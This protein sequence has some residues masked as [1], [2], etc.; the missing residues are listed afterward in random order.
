[1]RSVHEDRGLSSG[2]C[3][4]IP[5]NRVRP[6]LRGSS[7]SLCPI[8][9]HREA[10]DHDVSE[11]R[12][13]ESCVKG[14]QKD[15]SEGD[16]D[17]V[18]HRS[19]LLGRSS[20]GE[21]ANDLGSSVLGREPLGVLSSA[22]LR[23]EP[24]GEQFELSILSGS[25]E[26]RARSARAAHPEGASHAAAEARERRECSSSRAAET[27]IDLRAA[28]KRSPA[29]AASGRTAAPASSS[30]ANCTG[31]T[32]GTGA[33]GSGGTAVSG[34]DQEQVRS[35][36]AGKAGADRAGTSERAFL[37]ATG[38]SEP[39][40]S[41]SARN[42]AHDTVSIPIRLVCSV[43]APCE[44]CDCSEPPADISGTGSGSGSHRPDC[45]RP[46]GSHEPGAASVSLS[47]RGRLGSV[48]PIIACADSLNASPSAPSHALPHATQHEC[49]TIPL[50]MTQQ[51]NI[52]HSL[53]VLSSEVASAF[54]A[55]VDLGKTT[56]IEV[57]CTADSSLS[58][59]VLAAGGTIHR[60]SFWNGFDLTKQK[61]LQNLLN[62]IKQRQPKHIWF[63][64]PC[65]P[66]SPIQNMNQR[67]D[68][69][70][71]AL[72]QKRQTVLKIQ[73][74]IACA[75]RACMNSDWGCCVWLEQPTQCGSLRHEPFRSLL[76]H[77]FVAKTHGCAWGLRNKENELLKKPWSVYSSSP[78]VRRLERRCV[79]NHSHAQCLSG[80]AAISASYPTQLCT[81]LARIFLNKPT[82][83]EVEALASDCKRSHDAIDNAQPTDSTQPTDSIRT[84]DNNKR[85][86]TDGSDSVRVDN[87]P[88]IPDDSV[89]PD[90]LPLDKNA[91]SGNKKTR[92]HQ[93]APRGQRLPDELPEIL[94]KCS[95]KQ[96]DMLEARIAHL[97][98][99]LSHANMRTVAEMLVRSKAHPALVAMAKVWRC[100]ACDALAPKVPSQ[101]SGTT[102]YEPRQCLEIDNFEWKHP[103]NGI[104]SRGLC[105][106]DSGT[107]LP[108]MMIFNTAPETHSIGANTADECTNA[109]LL[110][111]FP[112]FGKPKLIR[113]DPQGCFCS[114]EW[115]LFLSE[116]GILPGL[117]P[118]EA[119][120]RTA[121]VERTIE[122]LKDSAFKLAR[123]LP[124]NT[125]TQ[126]IFSLVC[127]AHSDVSR[128]H[129]HS[130]YDLMLGG[131]A[132]TVADAD[133]VARPTS[134]VYS[135]GDNTGAYAARQERKRL[136]WHS[137]IDAITS[138]Q[139]K[140][141]MLA[142]TRTKLVWSAGELVYYWREG[143]GT[144]KA[145]GRRGKFHGPAR[146]LIQERKQERGQSVPSGIVWLSHGSFLIRCAPEHIRPA[147]SG[148]ED[149]HDLSNSEKVSFSELLSRLPNLRYE[150]IVSQKPPENGDL[151]DSTFTVARETGLSFGEPI[152]QPTPPPRSVS[153]QPA[154][155]HEPLL[156]HGSSELPQ[157]TGSPM[158]LGPVSDQQKESDALID[159]FLNSVPDEPEQD[160]IMQ[161]PLQPMSTFNP[162]TP[163]VPAFTDNASRPPPSQ[164]DV[165]Q[166]YG[167]SRIDMS[168]VL[169]RETAS[170]PYS[171][172][173]SSAKSWDQALASSC[174][175]LAP[176]IG[177]VP[178]SV[179]VS[180]SQSLSQSLSGFDRY[181]SRALGQDKKKHSGRP[182]QHRESAYFSDGHVTVPTD[183]PPDNAPSTSS[184]STYSEFDS[185]IVSFPIDIDT[186][187][188]AS[189]EKLSDLY[190][191]LETALSAVARQGR[192][193]IT[194]KT[195]TPDERCE[196]A[197]SKDKEISQWIKNS[198]VEAAAREG[199]S[200]RALMRM[201]WV[202]TRKASN[203]LKARLVVQGFTDPDLTSLKSASPTA[204]R[205]ARQCFFSIAA[206]L[207]YHV[208]KADVTAAFLSGDASEKERNILCEPV[209]ELSLAL[210]LKPHEVVRLRKAVYGLVN[211]PRAWWQHVNKTMAQLGWEASSV[212]PCLWTLRHEGKLV[213][214]TCVH[215][216]DFLIGVDETC[217]F[218][219]NAMDQFAAAYNFGTWEDRDFVVCGVHVRQA[220]ARGRWHTLALDQISYCEGIPPLDIPTRA[221]DH[222]R[223]TPYQIS[224]LRGLI[225]ALQWAATQTVIVILAPL[226]ILQGEMGDPTIAT[227][228]AANKLLRTA[229]EASIVP[230]IMHA[231]NNPAVVCYSDA[232]WAVRK[233][234]SSQS[235]FIVCLCDGDYL[236]GIEG[237]L[238]PI[239]WGSGKT[240]RV[241]RSS[242]A[243]EIQG[244]GDGQEEMEFCRLLIYDILIGSLDLYKA[245][246]AISQVPGV[247]ILDCKSLYDSVKSSESSALGMSDKRAAIE[248][249]ALKRALASTNTWIRWVHS[250]AQ[251]ADV[252]TKGTGPGRELFLRFMRTGR[253]RLVYDPTFTSARNRTKA[254]AG[255]LEDLV[256]SHAHDV[257]DEEPEVGKPEAPLPGVYSS[258]AASKRRAHVASLKL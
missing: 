25:S 28:G 91:F 123:E 1:M 194:T 190:N 200:T 184:K 166:G 171:K 220:Y 80:A 93:R 234:G 95:K 210:K 84:V 198:V 164:R 214:I 70:T 38:A 11:G 8:L 7:E 59:A 56:L 165:P 229:Q 155:A 247:L 99:N 79:G 195:L 35:R 51:C 158:S 46:H 109:L 50:S 58:R 183:P 212:E 54:S 175:D 43:T 129:G 207:G 156:S 103:R 121:L 258:L 168:S 69:Q 17:R 248:A 226:S 236:D 209:E 196:L 154:Q 26:H 150:D 241:C 152:V 141:A 223:L 87:I 110:N 92:L 88:D 47:R 77:L 73:R 221:P 213:G 117:Q 13:G 94:S 115:L 4:R 199:H 24:I 230:I 122:T 97:H 22:E 61:G 10:Y 188:G 74:S 130:P 138:S 228:R 232:A 21:P 143:R 204:S 63:S 162:N 86:Q 159:E 238:S 6:L 176:P 253:W 44:H 67:N 206:S 182:R 151:E 215:V 116:A 225:G 245:N 161:P 45:G 55:C 68:E 42:A 237:P 52:T 136:A 53:S 71:K 104:H 193:E 66:E 192:A 254:G 83:A 144:I 96:L 257:V 170:N 169:A 106:V 135:A 19:E 72:R 27:A 137:A 256:T 75:M 174:P 120:F 205:R 216:D 201:R 208:W 64:P 34:A 9:L 222:Q 227:A 235:G 127:A 18:I 119:H 105:I 173:S 242:L 102:V 217:A 180:A 178:A 179:V 218:A 244:A 172:A 181:A 147:T 98:K 62:T 145:P 191:H 126:E 32:D 108:I 133:D 189:P 233:D 65:G 139:V 160:P 167:P 78:L 101:V 148:E 211:A 82:A 114:K 5:D 100:E 33:A 107:R 157:P 163:H 15:H 31:S 29:F 149:L 250:E 131:S 140:R 3:S 49:I 243:A 251:L 90:S 219:R 240:K 23:T 2:Q 41:L 37:S 113:C 20:Q 124:D 40:V 187:P 132:D 111:W 14:V 142:K 255:T 57:C 81:M 153:L 128:S 36:D 202:I 39:A 118:G 76:Q 89:L 224:C 252:L 112:Y 30:S 239:S 125:S 134:L 185:I 186:T 60:C 16:D 146:V 246:E 197:T 249:L 177:I 85:R 12:Y 48:D 231:H 203:D